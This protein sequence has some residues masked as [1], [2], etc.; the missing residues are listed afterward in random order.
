METHHLCLWLL[1]FF[2][3]MLTRCMKTAL[4]CR[5]CETVCVTEQLH[6][7]HTGLIFLLLL[8]LML[9]VFTLMEWGSD[10][11]FSLTQDF[12]VRLLLLI[13]TTILAKLRSSSAL[14]RIEKATNL[15][16]PKVLL[17]CFWLGCSSWFSTHRAS[18][19][20]VCYNAV[21]EGFI[22]KVR[23]TTGFEASKFQTKGENKIR[24]LEAITI[25]GLSFSCVDSHDVSDT[26]SVS[27]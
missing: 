22:R 17:A 4:K 5:S 12:R 7:L 6:S 18:Q 27:S 21:T 24:G 16:L 13:Y 1:G 2:N 11:V 14:P 9:T 19:R 15:C 3:L 8:I 20:V 23:L 25:P 10:S 26:E